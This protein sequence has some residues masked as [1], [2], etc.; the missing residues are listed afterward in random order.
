M[1]Y[2]DHHATTPL[3]P[4]ALQA[5]LPL[6]QQQFANPGSLTHQAGREVA[7]IVQSSVVELARLIG[8][9]ADELVM[10]SGATESN[11]LALQGVMLHPR[12][13]R[14][15]IVS[16]VTEHKAI[17]DPLHRL[18]QQGFQVDLLPV[19]GQTS[20][21]P[22]RIDLQRLADAV[23]DQTALV[24]VMLANN[25]IGVLQ[26]MAEI[27]EICRKR[28][29]YLH[30]DAS[31]AVGR[32]AV[33]VDRLDV[34]LLSFSSHKFY[35][36]KGAGGLFV[37]RRERMVRLQGQIM[38]GG[39]QHNLRSGTLNPPGI[40]GMQVALSST[41]A[42]LSEDQRRIGQLRDQLYQRL[43][44]MPQL[45]LNGPPLIDSQRLSGNL[46]CCFYPLEGQSLM[47]HAPELAISSGSACTSANPEPS[48]VLRALGL[49]EDHARSSLR[50]GLGRFTTATE[51]DQAA[52][53]LLGAVQQLEQLR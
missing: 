3:D 39:Q 19:D 9:Q 7:E 4:L 12:Q 47:M 22:G 29:C 38:G 37:R 52:E 30:T 36:P 20:S 18:S 1:I 32:I 13:K 46:N 48:H 33:D 5:M 2:L 27:A 16:V 45:Q 53:M 40:V 49:S 14:R 28:G 11:N 23:D 42:S 24:S 31:Q 21:T 43:Q 15:K 10:T 50:F 34:D 25:E 41:L 6:F 44:A 8:A 35:G 51:I 26:P 17:L